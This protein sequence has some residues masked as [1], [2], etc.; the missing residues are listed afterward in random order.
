MYLF[1]MLDEERKLA[2]ELRKIQEAK[3]QIDRMVLM[4]YPPETINR[5]SRNFGCTDDF[6]SAIHRVQSQIDNL[7]HRIRLF[8]QGRAV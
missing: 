7:Q 2:D 8:I 3:Q 1:E 6:E 5:M 4:G